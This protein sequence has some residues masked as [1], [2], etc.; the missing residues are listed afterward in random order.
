MVEHP[1]IS[2]SYRRMR[3]IADVTDLVELMFPGN[4]NQQ[5]AAARILLF[6]RQADQ[7]QRSL[8]LL[9]RRHAISRRTLQ[10]TRAKL[11]RLGLIEHVSGLCARHGG[12]EGWTLSG[13][14]STAL[15]QLAEGLDGWRRAN[16]PEHRHKEEVLAGLLR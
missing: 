10:R 8:A 12:T 3:Q 1:K 6:L 9:E 2:F 4:R 13:R 15:R 14:M 7:P 11:A 16:D 5:H